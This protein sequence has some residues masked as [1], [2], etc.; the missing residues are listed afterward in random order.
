MKLVSWRE[1]AL[2]FL[3]RAVLE[4]ERM[5]FFC[6]LSWSSSDSVIT[7][8]SCHSGRYGEALIIEGREEEAGHRDHSLQD[9]A[10]SPKAT[11]CDEAGRLT[12]DQ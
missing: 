1:V 2:G 10:A 6:S 4:F 5:K 12:E 8:P 3:A 7:R 9:P 11:A